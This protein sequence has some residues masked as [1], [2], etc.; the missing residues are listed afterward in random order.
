MR[1]DYRLA[2]ADSYQGY[3]RYQQALQA[4]FAKWWWACAVS[5][6]T[7][8][9]PPPR[10]RSSPAAACAVATCQR[11]VRGRLRFLFR[12]DYCAAQ[13]TRSRAEPR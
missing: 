12:S 3:Y 13:R 10:P 7:A 9:P 11:A 1:A 8:P 6:T 4:G 2:V 5:K